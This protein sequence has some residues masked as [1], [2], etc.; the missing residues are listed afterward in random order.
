[1]TIESLHDHA[2]TAELRRMLGDQLTIVYLETSPK[3]REERGTAGPADVV[4]RDAVKARRGAAAISTLAH[5]VVNNNGSRLVLE[6]RLDRLALARRWPLRRPVTAPVNSLGLPVNL[7]SYLSALLDR[8]TGTPP[9]IDLLAVT[10]SGARG[11][12]QH[13]WSDLDIFVVAAQ[14]S[15]SRLRQALAELESELGGVKL[16]LTIVTQ[17]ECRTGALSSRLLHVLALIGSGALLPLW[18]SPGLALPAPDAATDVGTSVEAG[19][20][21]AVEIRRQLLKG[22]P[23]LRALFKVTALLAKVML[24]FTGV[25]CASDD[26]ALAVFLSRE[27]GDPG[28]LRS[29]ARGDRRKAEELAHSVLGHWLATMSSPEPVRK[30]MVR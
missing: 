11:K 26:D 19:I 22:T 27:P 15:T 28:D 4:E 16:G 23:D 24:R 30:G 10:G 17:D 12:Y 3:I 2:S 20:Q 14:E 13:G 5:E 7:E 29:D 9:L 6:R 25:E 18:Y 1:M 8:V 21:A